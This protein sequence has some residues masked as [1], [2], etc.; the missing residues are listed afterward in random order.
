MPDALADSYRKVKSVVAFCTS[1]RC[2]NK[3]RIQLEKQNIK[4]TKYIERCGVVKDVK[5]SAIDCPDCRSALVW[6]IKEYEVIEFKY[7]EYEKPRVH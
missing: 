5:I 7:Y 4:F 2:V 3:H 6:R 1:Q